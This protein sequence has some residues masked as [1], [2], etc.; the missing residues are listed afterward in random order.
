MPLSAALELL[1]LSAIVRPKLRRITQPVLIIHSRRDHT[2]PMRRNVTYLLKHLGSR[3]K[4]AV[5][6]EESFHVI[7]VDSEKD[8]VVSEVVEFVKSLRGRTQAA[9]AT[10]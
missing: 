5:I 2:C 1:K 9:S 6:L 4:R 3:Q 7:T 10:G 8:R